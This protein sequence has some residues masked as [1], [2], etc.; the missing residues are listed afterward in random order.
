MKWTFIVFTFFTFNCVAQ[1]DTLGLRMPETNAEFP[2][3]SDSLT[4]FIRENAI[5]Y[6]KPEDDT[7]RLV[8]VFIVSWDGDITDFFIEQ[9]CSN[10][11][12]AEAIRLLKIM[13]KWIPATDKGKPVSLRVRLPFV[14]DP[15]SPIP[16]ES[17][18]RKL[19]R[20]KRSK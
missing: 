2:G 19:F 3:G 4:A 15:P 14:F 9:G 5:N 1:N 10:S 11:M 7:F 12:N 13:P 6:L 18:K 8:V 17:K 20:R 16:E